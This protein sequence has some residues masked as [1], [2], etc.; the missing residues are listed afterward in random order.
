[1]ND[2]SDGIFST[3]TACMVGIPEGYYDENLLVRPYIQIGETA[4]YG[5]EKSESL[6]NAAKNSSDQENETIKKIIE[7]VEGK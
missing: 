6:Y 4:Y 3:Y 1:M 7:A 5:A 2:E